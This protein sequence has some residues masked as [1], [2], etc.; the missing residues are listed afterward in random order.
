MS[1]YDFGTSDPNTKSGTALATDLNSWRN[2]LHST[3]GGSSA[4]SY[5]TAGMLWLDTTSANYE[6]KLYDG[7]QSI[8]VAVI[9]ATNNVA[10]VAV[11]SAET[12]YITA[13]TAAQIK[14]VIASVDTATIRSTGLQFNIASPYIGDSSNNELISF[15]T[16]AS[17]VNQ[18]NV[19]NAATGANPVI[20][21]IGNDTNIGI[22][23]TPKGTGRTN[24][25]QLALDGTTITTTAAQLNFVTG[26]TSAIQTQLDGKAPLTGTG[27]S[28]TWPISISGDAATVDGKSIGTL[29]AAGGIAYATS[30]TALAAIGAGTAGQALLS[31]GAGAPTW[32][33]PTPTTAQIGTATAGL[34]AGDVGSYA[35]L[36]IS[37]NTTAP[38]GS[39]VAGS[40]LIY[41]NASGGNDTGVPAGTW[42]V[43]GRTN[44]TNS[45]A[46]TTLMLRI[47]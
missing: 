42:R 36:R 34:A 20:S 16:T 8:P 24:I 33:L 23:L 4:P 41:S 32:G 43:M 21:A 39:T 13:T 6:L 37:P 2:A 14:F 3:H 25:G 10:R 27:T 17:A 35:F 18:I 7:A 5:I 31:G 12:S 38:T 28:G 30:T 15:T 46:S 47:S 45:A 22:T 19:A 1:Q 9:D 11:D 44:S 40:S 29:T 26:V